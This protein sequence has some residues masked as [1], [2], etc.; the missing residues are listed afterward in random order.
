MPKPYDSEDGPSV[1]PAGRDNRFPHERLDAYA[2]ARELVA[3]VAQ[4]RACLRG[5]P[6]ETGR[7]WSVLW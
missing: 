4:N 5:L 3:F 2:V 7:S 6:G 1:V